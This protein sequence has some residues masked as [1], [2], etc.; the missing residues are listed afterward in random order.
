[1]AY[2]FVIVSQTKANHK[3]MF[4]SLRLK[5]L[6]CLNPRPCQ[7]GP[8]CLFSHQSFVVMNESRDSFVVMNESREVN[9]GKRKKIA[10]L[11]SNAALSSNAGQRIESGT[12]SSSNAGLT[13]NAGPDSK[14]VEIQNIQKEKITSS[15]LV[16]FTS[17]SLV[18]LNT[19]IDSKNTT[20]TINKKSKK[21]TSDLIAPKR[22][23]IAPKSITSEFIAPTS[24]TKPLTIQPS[25]KHGYPTIQPSLTS[26]IPREKRQ[27]VLE[28][29]YNEFTRIYQPLSTCL[30][31]AS[32]HALD[33][34]LQVHSKSTIKSYT[35]FGIGVLSRLRQ[36]S[37]AL[38]DQDVGIDGVYKPRV[39]EDNQAK[40]LVVPRPFLDG[41][42][43]SEELMETLEYPK[44]VT[45]TATT[46]QSIDE[47]T[48][49]K[50]ETCERCQEKFDPLQVVFK[51]SQECTYHWGRRRRMAV[52]TDRV[53]SCCQGE[54]QAA[55]CSVGPHVFKQSL[56]FSTFSKVPDTMQ[57]THHDLL[58]LDCEMGYTTKGFEL[59]R[60]TCVDWAGKVV[61]DTIVK[62][63]GDVIDF[64]SR[65]S[66][67]HVIPPD[68]LSF[69]ECREKLASIVG[70]NTILLGH[71]LENDLNS[72]KLIHSKCID[73]VVVFPHPSGL[74]YRLS[75]R[76]LASTKLGRFI[77]QG[78]HS[79]AEDALACL[80]LI[81]W[82]LS[83]DV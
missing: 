41:L 7:M 37:V 17:S 15:S 4:P 3:Q 59:L 39:L 34:E 76:D 81:K 50:M 79:S 6:E 12:Q 62:P 64:N 58:A 53:F 80:D 33:Q 70:P 55:G 56:D 82:K 47:D 27:K 61:L 60:L 57:P 2:S 67:V 65:F 29:Y 13:S 25:S 43:L 30:E 48:G 71:S 21:T 9:K 69:T 16:S 11:T 52:G 63:D 45:S 73:T 44:V 26:K 51:N 36:R 18:S 74:P 46:N 1:M 66:G 42:C 77:Q 5:G 28:K 68:A 22:E 75:L 24:T 31:L 14:Q 40:K 8:F 32:C 38:D 19:K 20:K 23:F 83:Q 35:T 72:L 78:E 10:G 54:L 49:P